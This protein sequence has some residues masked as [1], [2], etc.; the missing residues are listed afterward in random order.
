MK[1]LE[2]KSIRFNLPSFLSGKILTILCNHIVRKSL[3]IVDNMNALLAV[4]AG[5]AIQ[6]YI[7]RIHNAYPY[8]SFLY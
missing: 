5:I 1:V 6:V 4:P 8:F 7:Q 2:Y 3:S